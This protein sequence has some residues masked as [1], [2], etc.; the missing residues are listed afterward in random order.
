MTSTSTTRPLTNEVENE[1]DIEFI[2]K[3]KA[4]GSQVVSN[5]DI[6]ATWALLTPQF[7]VNRSM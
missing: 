6:D 5:L 2:F 3:I 1:D 4:I 7:L